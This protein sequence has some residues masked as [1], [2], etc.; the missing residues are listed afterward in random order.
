MDDHPAAIP[1]PLAALTT[2]LT[3]LKPNPFTVA[4]KHPPF[5]D[6]YAEFQLFHESFK[7]WFYLQ[8]VHAESGGNGDWK[9][10]VL[11]F[12]GITGH[13]KFNQW[14]PAGATPDY[15]ATAKKSVEGSLDYLV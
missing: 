13:R 15:C 4:L 10:Y 5:G 7:S 11:N 2:A 12:L 6:Q 1:D 8:G 9:M 14:K 3:A